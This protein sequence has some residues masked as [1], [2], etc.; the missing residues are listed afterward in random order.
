M[1]NKKKTFVPG[2]LVQWIDLHF[3]DVIGIVLTVRKE[4]GQIVI[5]TDEALTLS[6]NEDWFKPLKLNND[7]DIVL[8]S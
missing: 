2:D 6:I 4:D 7:H 3:Y 5:L 8:V 1:T